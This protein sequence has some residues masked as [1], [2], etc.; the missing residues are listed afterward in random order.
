MQHICTLWGGIL[1]KENNKCKN[2]TEE[3]IFAEN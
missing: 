1:L 3:A 2:V